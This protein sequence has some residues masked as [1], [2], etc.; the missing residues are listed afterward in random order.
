MRY[1]TLFVATVLLCAVTLHPA[2]SE[3]DNR[4]DNQQ[5]DNNQ[6][7]NQQI[8]DNQERDNSNETLSFDKDSN[9]TILIGEDSN[10]TNTGNLISDYAHKRNELEKE[11]RMQ[12]LVAIK[13]CRKE[14]K[15]SENRTA[16]MQQCKAE[17]KT[18]H[19]QF[20]LDLSQINAEFKQF[21]QDVIPG[22]VQLPDQNKQ[23]LYNVI[24][25][26]SQAEQNYQGANS[27]LH[28]HGTNGKSY[29]NH[30][31][32]S[33]DNGKPNSDQRDD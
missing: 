33:G 18:I 28:G 13:D 2:F 24:N 6:V 7:E 21:R 3:D 27:F 25:S 9:R 11:Q 20:L 4:G 15:S 32:H 22:M 19:A 23:V 5:T 30:S 17:F 10:E 31:N 1:V 16:T 26:L 12:I 14:I 8:G 29:A